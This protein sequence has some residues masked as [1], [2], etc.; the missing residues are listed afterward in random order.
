LNALRILCDEWEGREI[1][2]VCSSAPDELCHQDWAIPEW[3]SSFS[4]HHLDYLTKYPDDDTCVLLGAPTAH[5]K[6]STS[7]PN[8]FFYRNPVSKILSA[9]RYHSRRLE[10]GPGGLGVSEEWLA[11]NATCNACDREDH[12]LLFEFCDGCGYNSLLNSVDKF[13]AVQ[14]EVLHSAEELRKMIQVF[15]MHMNDPNFLYVSMD[16]LRTDFDSTFKC[17]LKFMGRASESSNASLWSR[18][19]KLDISG[20][21]S[22]GHSTHSDFDNTEVQSFLETHSLLGGIFAEIKATESR[23]FER[24]QKMYGCP[25]PAY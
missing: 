6:F 19:K 8:V 2:R 18:L 10:G 9:Y 3:D 15:K 21:R 13:T 4:Q 23:L 11:M 7:K 22:S 14:L 20:A 24:Q 1:S 16:H 25:L 5:V 17:M 12:R